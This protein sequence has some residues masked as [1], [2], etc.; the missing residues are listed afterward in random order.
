M[1]KH[2]KACADNQHNFKSLAFDNFGF[3]APKVI[4]LLK[5]IQK[6]MHSNIVWPRFMNVV[7]RRSDFAMENV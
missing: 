3:L 2:E 7:F 4:N 1:A 5:R 6:V